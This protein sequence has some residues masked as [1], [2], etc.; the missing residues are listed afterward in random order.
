M[1]SLITRFIRAIIQVLFK[2]NY[3]R[4]VIDTI[5]QKIRENAIDITHQNI[6]YTLSASNALAYYRINTFSTKEPETLEWINNFANNRV[7][8]DIGANVGLYSIYAAKTKNVQI[9]SFEPSVFNLESIA[10]NI[11]LNKVADKIC[12]VPL[13][14]SD[15]SQFNMM[16]M[17]STDWGGALSSFGRDVGWDG[18]KMSVVF[19]YQVLGSSIDDMVSRL[20][21]PKPHYI[22]IDVD[23]I[24]HFILNGGFSI[25]QEVEEVLIEVNDGFLEQAEI[26]E[27]VLK[28]AGLTL[29]EKRHS[30]EFDQVG[31]FGEGKVWNQ[32]WTRV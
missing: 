31:A 6:Q 24:E 13:P 26:C 17:T 12:I 25:L 29:K 23:G 27:Q 22:K 7:F 16:Q 21:L 9:F 30:E 28:N 19:N 18:N 3:G 8:W 11:N 15:T 2:S 5:T 32:I 14:L 20:S 1:R 4:W 10:R